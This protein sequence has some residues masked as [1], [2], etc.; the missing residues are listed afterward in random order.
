MPP[1]VTAKASVRSSPMTGERFDGDPRCDR[2]KALPAPNATFTVVRSGGTSAFAVNFATADS[3][4]TAVSDYVPTSGTLQFATGVNTQTISV[5]INGDT[6]FEP[7]D[8][9]FINLSG[10]TNG[11]THQ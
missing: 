9:F 6:T 11:A 10:A 1:S 3:T 2:H 7:N 8:T 5:P 4:A